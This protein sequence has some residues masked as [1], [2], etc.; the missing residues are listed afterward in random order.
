MSVAA[1]TS[2]VDLGCSE[3]PET[4]PELLP[5]P[6]SLAMCLTEPPRGLADIAS[7]VLAAPWLLRSP[8][9]DGHPILVLPGLLASDTSTMAMRAYLRLLG[10]RVHGWNLGINTGPTPQVVDGLPGVLAGLADRYDKPVSVIGW[11]LGGIYARQ[12]ARDLPHA[13]RQVIT[14]GSPFGLSNLQQTRVGALYS[15]MSGNHAIL[16]PV[17]GIEWELGHPLPVPATALYS[18][19]D[20]VVPWQVC[21]DF[22]SD[23][24]ESVAVHGSHM[25]LTHNPS[26][27]WAVADRLAQAADTWNPFVVPRHLRRLYPR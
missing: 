3:L 10:Y 19:R 24:S 13:V 8:R 21:R 11:S 4:F 12:L 14:L 25:G 16:P 20:G 18:K 6:P 7:L 2:V 17:N 9:G 26:A 5:G 1:D 27:L 22:P 15:R 23:R